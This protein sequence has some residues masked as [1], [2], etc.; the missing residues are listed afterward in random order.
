MAH[1]NWSDEA[2]RTFEETIAYIARVSTFAAA[3][4]ADAILK[5]ASLIAESPYQGSMGP[6][7]VTPLLR[8]RQ[9]Y[10]Y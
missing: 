8:E 3:R 6:E 7:Y 5:K 10:K 9:V 2:L 1:L 4:V